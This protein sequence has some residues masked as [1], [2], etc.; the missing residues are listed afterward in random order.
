MEELVQIIKQQKKEIEELK[1]KLENYDPLFEVSDELIGEDQYSFFSNGGVKQ[2][3]DESLI[4][5][6][7]YCTAELKKRSNK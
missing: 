3:S 4:D 7:Y 1:K 5:M 6:I 2:A